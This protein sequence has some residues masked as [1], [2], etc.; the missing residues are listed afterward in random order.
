MALIPGYNVRKA[1][2]VVAFFAI[3]QGGRINVLKLS[4]LVYLS[5]RAFVEKYDVPILYDKL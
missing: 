4:K 3:R 1:A 2:Q 5:D